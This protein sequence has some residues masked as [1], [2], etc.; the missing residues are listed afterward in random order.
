MSRFWYNPAP[1]RTWSNGAVGYG[2]GGPFDCLGPYVKVTNCPI[3]GTEL[4]RTCYAT[5]YPD[6]F[7]SVP[8]YTRYKGRYVSGFFTF[9]SD[10]NIKFIPNDRHRDRLQEA[11]VNG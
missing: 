1:Q 10:D 4:R 9:D 11:L 6:T 5:G 7:F 8:A 2:Q 3:D